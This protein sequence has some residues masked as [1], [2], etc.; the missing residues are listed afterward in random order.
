VRE[1]VIG[2]TDGDFT[3]SGMAFDLGGTWD[4]PWTG[5]RAGAAVRH[6]GGKLSYDFSG[7]ESFDLPTTLQAGISYTRLAVGGGTITVAGDFVAERGADASIR[8]GGE[9]AY[10]G[11]FILGA[12]YKTGLDNENVS[13]GVGYQNRIRVNYAFTPIYSDLGS[14]HRISLGYGW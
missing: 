6:L 2:T 4:T 1:S 13:F 14:S 10:R 11:Q 7:A 3:L 9:Y 5:V 12:G 8:V